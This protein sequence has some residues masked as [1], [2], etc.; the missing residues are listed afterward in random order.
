MKCS[1]ILQWPLRKAQINYNQFLTST[2]AVSRQLLPI[3]EAFVR[4]ELL[5]YILF[6]KKIK[7]L[8]IEVSIYFK[9]GLPVALKDDKF[10]WEHSFWKRQLWAFSVLSHVCYYLVVYIGC[11]FTETVT[12][13][14]SAW[15]RCS[16]STY[17]GNYLMYK[18]ELLYLHLSAVSI[19]YNIILMVSHLCVYAHV[20][21]YIYIYKCKCVYKC[22]TADNTL[23]GCSRFS[24]A[25]NSRDTTWHMTN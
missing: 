3:L 4:I 11:S 13:K 10:G 12:M 20:Y 22:V 15:T 23:I 24:S 19:I 21:T 5:G 2:S 14:D 7:K 16:P 18:L 6:K 9:L 1:D 8:P 17:M 25:A